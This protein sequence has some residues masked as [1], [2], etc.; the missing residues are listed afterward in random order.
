MSN[1]VRK[2]K[3]QPL[4]PREYG[5]DYTLFVTIILLVVFGL[6]MLYSI[7]YYTGVTKNSDPSFYL[8]KQGIHAAIGIIGMFIV[9]WF[10]QRLSQQAIQK[11]GFFI[12]VFSLA[13]VLLVPLVGVS[14]GGA[15]RWLEVAGVR[16]QP[17]ELVKVGIIL[18]VPTVLCYFKN[19]ALKWHELV[20]LCFV[21]FIPTLMVF[22]LTSN[23][24]TALIIAGMG[25]GISLLMIKNA[26][27]KMFLLIILGIMLVLF[28]K[29][30]GEQLLTVGDDFRMSRILVWIDPEKYSIDGGYQ[31]LQSLYAIG[32]GGFFGKGLG[33]GMQKISS[34][35]EVQNDMIFAAICEELGLFGV[36]MVM[37]LFGIIIYRSYIIAVNA[38]TLYDSLV[39]SGV[40]LHIAI[41]VVFNLAVVTAI[42][43]NTGV[44]LPFISYGGTALLI[45]MLEVGM[46]LGISSK[47]R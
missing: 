27:K 9:S 29:I 15:T 12:Y 44:T 36:I 14:A 34:I 4:L 20:G 1:R 21:I 45:I 18:F 24:S 6:V 38:P 5:F 43:P 8:R 30:F 23:L 32:A 13:L 7:S 10:Y 25:I 33:N 3:K 19:E 28:V 42:F 40:M 47:R 16:F 22:K 39:A 2:K 17:S 46:L 41:Q 31:V 11:W 37:A 26:G 35:P